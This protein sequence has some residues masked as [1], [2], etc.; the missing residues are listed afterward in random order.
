MPRV[1]TYLVSKGG[2]ESLADFGRLGAKNASTLAGALHPMRS[3][4]G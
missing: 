1:L 4:W 2:A 3:P